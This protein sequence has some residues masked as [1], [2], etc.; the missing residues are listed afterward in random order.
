MA[1]THFYLFSYFPNKLLNGAIQARDVKLSTGAKR[2]LQQIVCL[3]AHFSI[4]LGTRYF[5]KKMQN[6]HEN[7]F[8]PNFH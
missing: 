7:L 1:S 6:Q 5:L 3:K 4:E 2:G 8:L